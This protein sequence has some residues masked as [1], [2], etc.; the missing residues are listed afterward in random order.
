MKTL[1]VNMPEV[2]SQIF[3]TCGDLLIT[4]SHMSKNYPDVME[5]QTEP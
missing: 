2:A 5:I 1:L 3:I 4:K